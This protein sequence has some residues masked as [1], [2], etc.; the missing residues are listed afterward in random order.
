MGTTLLTVMEPGCFTPV[1]KLG[2]K[3]KAAL[4][5][6]MGEVITPVVPITQSGLDLCLHG[7]HSALTSLT[8]N[9]KTPDSAL[10]ALPCLQL[11]GGS[12]S[13]KSPAVFSSTCVLSGM[14]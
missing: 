8:G 10:S 3:D 9:Q 2:T 4:G 12:S 11:L 1:K 5:K 7:G 13:H 14:P 6:E